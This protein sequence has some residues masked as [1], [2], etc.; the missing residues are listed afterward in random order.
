MTQDLAENHTEEIMPPASTRSAGY[1]RD[2]STQ[3]TAG[4]LLAAGEGSRTAW[5]EI[6]RRYGKHVSWTVRSFR[7]QNADA[8]DA[9]QM[10]WLRLVENCHRIRCP[11]HL[12]GW[13]S[14]TARR[15]CL[16]ILRQSRRT[17][18]TADTAVD[19][20]ADPAPGPE[21]RAVDADF[22]RTLRHL[23]AELPHR[24]RILLRT[25]FADRPRTYA[26]ITRATGIPTGSI[27]PTRARTLEQLRRLLREHGLA[28]VN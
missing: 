27:G 17:P 9:T 18:R 25:L 26:E 11:E 22:S 5:D 1:T 7:L 24:Q 4:L 10:T 20:I 13:L 16:R 28:R 3:T 14:T 12:G 15:E 23:V 2:D 21:Q 8:F 6:V 19:D